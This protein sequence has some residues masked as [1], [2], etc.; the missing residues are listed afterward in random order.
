M[1]AHGGKTT[2]SKLPHSYKHPTTNIT[3]TPNADVAI[4]LSRNLEYCAYGSSAIFLTDDFDAAEAKFGEVAIK[5]RLVFEKETLSNVAGR[6][7]RSELRKEGA[8][9]CVFWGAGV[10][11][12]LR[13]G[14][15]GAH[16]FCIYKAAPP[17]LSSSNTPP[18]QQ[19]HPLPLSPPKHKNQKQKTLASTA[20]CA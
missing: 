16:D 8:G 12:G 19:Q 13:G 10:V 18:S 14:V 6:V 5:E 15:S 4:L 2:D 3:N 17:P 11:I 1:A 9:A 7:G 20:G